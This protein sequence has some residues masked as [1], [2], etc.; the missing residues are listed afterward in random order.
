MYSRCKAL[1]TIDY[2][3]LSDPS[4]REK[5]RI[6]WAENVDKTIGD[7]VACLQSADRIL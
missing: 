6:G 4:H 3:G 5:G 2:G 1:K 7:D